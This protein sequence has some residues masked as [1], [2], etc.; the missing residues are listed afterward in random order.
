MTE[1]NPP[2][3]AYAQPFDAARALQNATLYAIIPLWLTSGFVD[4]LH[5]RKS[6]IET[7]SGTH[8][9]MI[10]ALQMTTAGI[11]TLMGLLLEVNASVV[12]TMIAATTAHEALTFWDIGYAES[13]RRPKPNEQHTHSFLEVVPIMALTSTLSLHPGQTAALFGRGDEPPRWGLRVKDPPLS[14]GYLAAIFGAVMLLGVVPYAEEFIRCYRTDRTL[15]AHDPPAQTA[16]SDVPP[17][18]GAS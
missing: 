1:P 17:Q 7:T 16:S 8:E 11:P 18:A 12:A 6:S 4:Y 5:H 2:A 15:A 3:E 13:L 14:R 10:H 9:S